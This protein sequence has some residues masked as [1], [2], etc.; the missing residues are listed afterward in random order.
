MT[1][2]EVSTINDSPATAFATGNFPFPGPT[3]PGNMIQPTESGSRGMHPGKVQHPILISPCPVSRHD[4]RKGIP[5]RSSVVIAP[6]ALHR[7]P[8]YWENPEA[9]DPAR[10]ESASPAAYIPFGTG[11]RACIGG[12]FAMME[13][14]FVVAMVLQHFRLRPATAVPVEPFPG[15]TLRTRH[16]LMMHLD[17]PFKP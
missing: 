5:A 4:G 6:Y 15:L 13:A 12:Q 3:T 2:G 7:H 14:Q 1:W 11:P 9:F 17:R 10:F 8:E 16:G